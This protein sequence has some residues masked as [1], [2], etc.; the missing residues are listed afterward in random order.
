M[1]RAAQEPRAAMGRGTCGGSCVNLPRSSAHF[2]LFTSFCLFRRMLG[3]VL[4]QDDAH[5]CHEVQGMCHYTRMLPVLMP[6]RMTSLRL[7]QC[8]IDC[9]LA[10]L[11]IRKSRHH[12]GGGSQGGEDLDFIIFIYIFSVLLKTVFLFYFAALFGLEWN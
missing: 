9:V 10:Y 7:S 4:L 1:V 5:M 11:A 12:F 8:H 6:W 3:M 2:H